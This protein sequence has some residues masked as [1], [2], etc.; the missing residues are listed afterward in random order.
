MFLR[1]NC[2]TKKKA[3]QSAACTVILKYLDDWVAWGLLQVR[4]IW[5]DTCKPSLDGRMGCR[6][7]CLNRML[8]IECVK[9]TCPCGDLCSIS[10]DGGW[11]MDVFNVINPDRSKIKDEGVV[12]YI[13]K[14]LKSDAFYVPSL[15]GSVG[16][17]PSEDYTVIELAG[18]DRPGLLSKVSAVLTNLGCNVV[19]AEIWTHNVRATTV[20]HVTDEKTRNAV[21]PW[22]STLFA[23]CAICG[24]ASWWAWS[25]CCWHGVPWLCY[26]AQCNGEFKNDM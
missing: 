16:L 3:E 12:N 1:D 13:K 22:C 7:E 26:S 4:W 18:I 10:S 19:N 23:S 6:D 17:K 21:V 20:V 15:T 11:F 2:L 25:S 5:M 8:N 24:A 9:G 14:V